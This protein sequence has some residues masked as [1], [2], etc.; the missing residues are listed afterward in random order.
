M[1]S[2]TIF[3]AISTIMSTE[4]V[5]LV[6][7]VTLV[8]PL[9]SSIAEIATSHEISSIFSRKPTRKYHLSSRQSLANPDTAEVVVA[10]VV[11][12]AVEVGVELPATEITE[13]LL[14]AVSAD[15][16]A[17]VTAMVMVVETVIVEEDTDPVAAVV[18]VVVVVVVVVVVPI[19]ALPRDT[20]VEEEEVAVL[21]PAVGGRCLAS[22]QRGLRPDGLK[23]F[24]YT[25][26]L[27]GVACRLNR[28]HSPMFFAILG[29]PRLLSRFL[30]NLSS[31]SVN[32]SSFVSFF[33][34]FFSIV[35]QRRVFYL[36]VQPLDC[37]GPM[38]TSKF[39]NRLDFCTAKFR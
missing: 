32:I 6:V 7:P 26:R 18:T 34:F 1:S 8:F 2:I 23:I 17:A 9:H 3:Q 28:F 4:S 11:S 31:V 21:L 15:T 20:A 5:V 36:Q 16:A 35:C 13:K 30:Q 24:A 19:T 39:E 29:H 14:V 10:E 37:G 27:S 38:S 33:F 22:P 12:A 25:S